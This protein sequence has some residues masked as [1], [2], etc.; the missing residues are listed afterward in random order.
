[1]VRRP[2]HMSVNKKFLNYEFG[3]NVYQKKSIDMD[4]DII[5]PR[6]DTTKDLFNT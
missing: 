2:I 5:Y 1:M 4:I 3:H 6:N